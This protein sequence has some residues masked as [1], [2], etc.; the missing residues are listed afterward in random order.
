VL[1]LRFILFV[2]DNALHFLN[3]PG[4]LFVEILLVEISTFV[5]LS[6]IV[7]SIFS[8]LDFGEELGEEINESLIFSFIKNDVFKFWFLWALFLFL[9]RISNWVRDFISSSFSSSFSFIFLHLFFYGCIHLCFFFSTLFLLYIN[10][11]E[12]HI[13]Y[14]ISINSQVITNIILFFN[15]CFIQI[16]S[17]VICKN[18]IIK[19]LSISFRL[20]S[21]NA[22]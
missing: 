19:C 14:I 11:K 4:Q 2:L 12:M 3:H 18:N 6:E 8:C 20:N 15:V 22:L 21:D 7:N 16:N 17:F 13:I 1:N 10:L 5:V 9:Y